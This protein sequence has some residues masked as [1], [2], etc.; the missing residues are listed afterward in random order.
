MEFINNALIPMITFTPVEVPWNV[1]PEV[2]RVCRYIG[3]FLLVIWLIWLA[4]QVAIPKRRNALQ[5]GGDGK[6]L[7]FIGAAV[8][9]VILMDINMVPTIINWVIAGIV[10][11]WNLF[12]GG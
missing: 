3:F 1:T 9:I 6:L 10:G 12:F 2:V 4:A 5:M 11:I 8:V 7:Q